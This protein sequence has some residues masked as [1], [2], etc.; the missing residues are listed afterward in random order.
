MENRAII[1]TRVSD[2]SQ[3]ENNS[4]ETQEK[5]CRNFAKLKGLEVVKVFVEEGK[6]AKHTHNRPRLKEALA[7]ASS[8]KNRIGVF[9]VY[10]F[11]RFSRNLEEGLATISLLAKYHVEVMSAI[12]DVEQG[13]MGKA[14]RNIMMTLGELDNELKGERVKDNMLSSFRKGLWPFKPPIGYIRRFKT[15]EENKGLP[16]IPAPNLSPIITTMFQ[17][18]A[19][20]IYSKTQLAKMMNMDG[21]AKYYTTKASHKM[22]DEILRRTFYYGNMH[23]PKWDEYARGLHTPI[24]DQTT[25]E[26]AYH[27]VI[28]KKK[29]YHYQ[30]LDLYPLKGYIVCEK[31]GHALTTSPSRGNGG[32]TPYYECR[33]LGCKSVRINT[34]SVTEQFNALLSSIQP[35]ARVILLFQKLV[36]NEWDSVI[37][38]STKIAETLEQKIESLKAELKSIRKAVDSGI[39]SEQEAVE[40][41]NKIRVE[42]QVTQIEKSEIRIEQYNTEIMREFINEFLKDLPRFWNRLDL[43][44]RQA[45]MEKVFN[46]QLLGTV[47][48]KIR[49]SKLSPSF[50]LIQSLTARKGENV[51]P[52]GFEPM[53]TG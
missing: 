37:D 25:W 19:K 36:E 39:Y 48:K 6:S 4:L 3:I 18:A 14:L 42:I 52:I 7:Y 29:N 46:G 21:F 5:S 34:N 16:P 51:T 2:P 43:P 20:G 49:T 50:K 40:E 12:E 44:K 24:I 26:A 45:F 27:K 17:N 28:L 11:D 23:A 15:K 41:A 47:D 9:L 30:E 22:V 38:R 53:L 1:Y 8:K 31:C 10:K 13:P 33:K 35:T 32:L